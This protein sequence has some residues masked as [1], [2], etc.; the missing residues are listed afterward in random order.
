M[1]SPTRTGAL[2]SAFALLLLAGTAPHAGYSFEAPPSHPDWEPGIEALQRLD[3][4]SAITHLRQV[5]KN[6]TDN[7]DARNALGFAYLSMKRYDSALEQLRE[8]IRLDP[9]HLSAHENTGRAYLATGDK[10]KAR[11]QLATLKRLCANGC[12]EERNLGRAFAGGK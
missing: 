11:E 9:K 10:G 3:Y 6:Q 12:E 8:A 5:V 7:A 1:W 4:A 2:R